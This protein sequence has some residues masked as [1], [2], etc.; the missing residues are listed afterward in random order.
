MVDSS[1]RPPSSV[2]RVA[3]VRSGA[4]RTSACSRASPRRRRVRAALRSAWSWCPAFLEETLT[5]S[6]TGRG[7]GGRAREGQTAASFDV[8][9]CEGARAWQRLGG[10]RW[11]SLSSSTYASTRKLLAHS[12]EPDSISSMIPITMLSD[13][14]SE[15]SGA[16]VCPS[17][18][19]DPARANANA[20]V[21]AAQDRL[22]GN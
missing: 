3:G 18:G 14:Q 4:K 2:S 10:A 7:L 17:G 21:A 5:L 19:T 22:G 8:A 9:L 12:S 15:R 1:W 6:A 13:H 20:S 16:R 11:A